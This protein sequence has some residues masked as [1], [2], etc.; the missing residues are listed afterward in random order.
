MYFLAFFAE[1]ELLPSS[2]YQCYLYRLMGGL[3]SIKVKSK[4]SWGQVGRGDAEAL[5]WLLWQGP[6]SHL[7]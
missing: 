1:F 4:R 6:M 3:I 5:Q 7:S 2:I